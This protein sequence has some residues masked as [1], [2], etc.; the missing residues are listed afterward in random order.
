MQ[1]SVI[2]QGTHSERVPPHCKN[3]L[4]VFYIPSQQGCNDVELRRDQFII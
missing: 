4:T 3:A 2:I 1:F